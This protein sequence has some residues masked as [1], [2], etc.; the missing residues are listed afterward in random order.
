MPEYSG[1]EPGEFRASSNADLAS[2]L[3]P[4]DES[5][6]PP[7]YQPFDAEDKLPRLRQLTPDQQQLSLDQ[8]QQIIHDRIAEYS[9]QLARQQEG[10]GNLVDEL[11]LRVNKEPA[12]PADELLALVPADAPN[13]RLN[14][15]QLSMFESAL[16]RYAKQHTA[17]DQYRSQHPD[18]TELFEH[19]FGFKPQGRVEVVQGPMTLAFLC[20]NEKDYGAIYHQKDP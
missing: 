19:T 16:S 7:E 3:R 1:P 11:Y 5:P 4:V 8:Q 14:K 2:G 18:D 17:V 15:R 13:Y 9:D 10:I 12:T 20:F 6:A